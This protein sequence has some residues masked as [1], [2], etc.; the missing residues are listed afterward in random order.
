M[1]T[2]IGELVGMIVVF[3]VV[4]K[5]VAPPVRKLMAKQQETVRAQIE[6]SEKARPTWPR[7]S[8]SGLPRSRKPGWRPRRSARTRAPTRSASPRNCVIRPM[9]R[10]SGSSSRAR[11]RS[12]CSVSS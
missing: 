6:A 9:S 12:C 2:F 1:A 8:E 7:R 10:S 4:F 3:W 5:Y 11:N